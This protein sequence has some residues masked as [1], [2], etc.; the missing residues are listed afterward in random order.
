MGWFRINAVESNRAT[1]GHG[2]RETL[3]HPSTIRQ[4][5][6]WKAQGPRGCGGIGE[7]SALPSFDPAHAGESLIE[8]ARVKRSKKLAILNLSGQVIFGICSPFNHRL[9]IST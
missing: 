3:G 4:A 8:K 5:H 6:G 1:R 2:D 7:G 9:R